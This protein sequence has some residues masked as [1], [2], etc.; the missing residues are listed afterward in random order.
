MEVLKNNLGIKDKVT[1]FAE[2]IRGLENSK[3]IYQY[4]FPKGTLLKGILENSPAHIGPFKGALDFLIDLGTPILAPAPGTV[5][6]VVDIHNQYGPDE[7]YKDYLN[8]LTIKHEYGEYSQPAHLAKGSSLVHVG[9]R[10]EAGQPLAL[11]GQSGWMSE[12]HLHLLVFKLVPPPP[13]FKGLKIKL[14]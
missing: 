4:P 3:N 10:V 2:L 6:E 14:R 7:R 12:P 8:Y 5:I 13:G 9:Q 1:A 11:T